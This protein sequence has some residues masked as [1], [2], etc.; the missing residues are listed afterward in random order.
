MGNMYIPYPT[1]IKED[2]V[3]LFIN[4]KVYGYN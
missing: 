3:V 2:G 1:E 4:K